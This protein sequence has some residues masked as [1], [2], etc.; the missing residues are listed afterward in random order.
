MLGRS[1]W[2]RCAVVAQAL[3]AIACGETEA[4]H[5]ADDVA[6]DSAM[7]EGDG[8]TDASRAGADSSAQDGAAAQDGASDDG[9]THD[10]DAGVDNAADDSTAPV[11]GDEAAQDGA[12]DDGAADSAG[13]EDSAGASDATLDDAADAADAGASDATGDDADAADAGPTCAAPTAFD[14]A[15]DATKPATCPGGICA[16]GFCIGPKLDPN[17]WKDCG[18]G[19]C[20]PCESATGCPA[21]CGS[22][23]TFTGAKD[24]S[25]EKTVTIWVHGFTNKKPADIAKM[26]YGDVKGCGDLLESLAL[27]GVTRPC[28]SGAEV[29][30]SPQHMVAVEYYGSV[31]PGWMTAKDIADVEAYPFD[32]GA[33][34]LERYA[35]IVAKFARWRM[36]VSGATH[37]QFACHSMGCLITR[38][39]IERDLEQLAST[40]KIVR[41]ASNT[42]V[43]AGARLARLYDNPAIQ[44]GATA[45]GL[46]LSDFVLMNPDHV[47][48]VTAAW[49]HKLYEGNNP[50]WKGIWIHHSVATNPKIQ[51]ALGIQLLDLN[52][53]GDEPNDGIMYSL[54]QHF[55]T[56]KA[57]GASV[58]KAGV[59][60]PSTRSYAY[61]DHMANPSSLAAAAV[62]AAALFHKRRVRVVLE[63]VE[64]YNDLEADGPF[65][66]KNQG[67]PPAEVTVEVAVRYDP[68]LKA[69]FGKDV[70]ISEQRVAHRS[71]E[72]FSAAQN[73]VVKPELVVYAG[74]VFD[75]QPSISL[76]VTLLEA[77]WY[78]RFGVAEW[79][80]DIHEELL[81]SNSVVKLE[82][83]S[84]EV[85]NKLARMKLRVELHELP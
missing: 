74:P 50:L 65:D 47:L 10:D 18:D 12:S 35:R 72:L 63:E 51:Q 27:F 33:M 79:P 17:R 1:R 6:A 58:T 76:Q 30:K 5:S 22:A 45:I 57:S 46:E 54:D 23:P 15:C 32:K 59:A 36:E 64:L 28:G 41:W 40:Q 84:F 14:Y 53:P 20:G 62:T 70:L 56:Q 21:D 31:A 34:G 24:L 9:E 66:L 29:A 61:F 85:K 44:Q 16:F 3:T 26:V 69:T 67:P 43:I 60:L 19:V 39:L 71:A 11:D 52:N 25:G 49:D 2:L 42:G 82:N 83:H 48:D 68:W 13:D 78:P 73:T 77:D 81:A 37:V 38:H 8:T 55:W 75:L 80:L 7:A 4:E